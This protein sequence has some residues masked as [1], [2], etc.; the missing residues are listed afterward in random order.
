M[1]KEIIEWHEIATRIPT[2]EERDT[3]DCD[4]NYIFIGDMPENGDEILVATRYGIYI[5]TCEVDCIDGNNFYFLED[6]EDWNGVIAW[7]YLPEGPKSK[8]LGKK[9]KTERNV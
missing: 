1:I 9:G 3:I 4:F 2:V 8:S 5:D 7:A 6:L